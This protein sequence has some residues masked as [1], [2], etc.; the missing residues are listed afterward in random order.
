MDYLEG[1]FLGKLWSDT[2]FENRRHIELFMLYGILTALFVGLMFWTGNAFIGV[3]NFNLFQKI[4]LILISIANPFM[5]FRYYRMPLWGKILV[6]IG[7]A[8]KAYLVMSLTVALIIPRITVKSSGI[9]DFLINFLNSTLEK[10][11]DKFAG[12]GGSF[13]TVMGVFA[14]G[15]HVVLVTVGIILALVLIPGVIFLIYKLV[16]YIFDYIIDRLL[17]RKVFRYKR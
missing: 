7:K 5:C 12:N 14:G 3:G 10:Y 11:T 17:I 8:F 15:I 6:L 1:L 4:A 13:A 2:D 16:Q 9:K